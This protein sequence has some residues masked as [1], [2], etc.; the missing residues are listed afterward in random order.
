[1]CLVSPPFDR[2][3]LTLEEDAYDGELL[4]VSSSVNS[5]LYEIHSPL[6]DSMIHSTGSKSSSNLR[7][8][9]PPTPFFRVYMHVV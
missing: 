2:Q 1:M 3:A 9:C 4:R 7:V 6:C 5:C 8:P